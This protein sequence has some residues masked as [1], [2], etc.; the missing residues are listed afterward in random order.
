MLRGICFSLLKVLEYVLDF[1]RLGIERLS[2]KIG[3]HPTSLVL[4]FCA[5]IFGLLTVYFQKINHH[6]P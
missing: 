3:E 1:F 6:I 5:Q 4:S 2:S